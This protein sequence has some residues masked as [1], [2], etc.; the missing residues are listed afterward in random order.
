MSGHRGVVAAQEAQWAA[1]AHQCLKK[2]LAQTIRERPDNPS[3]RVVEHFRHLFASTEPAFGLDAQIQKLTGENQRLAAEIAQLR[4]DSVP[5]D[6]AEALAAAAVEQ[7]AEQNQAQR[8]ERDAGLYRSL[9]DT[10]TKAKAAEEARAREAKLADKARAVAEAVTAKLAAANEELRAENERLTALNVEAEA[11]LNV[12]CSLCTRTS[13]LQQS[14]SELE[15][16]VAGPKGQTEEA[17]AAGQKE[18][19]ATAPGREASD[20]TGNG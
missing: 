19:L 3:L 12:R 2:A 17:A 14:Q 18:E 15:R 6:E 5:K 11:K 4:A 7:A 13:K 20:A 10:A 8:A 16:F 9:Q 1:R